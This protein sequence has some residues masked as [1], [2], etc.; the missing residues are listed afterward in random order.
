[1]APLI[2][3]TR[4]ADGS[5]DEDGLGAIS[6][7]ARTTTT[8]VVGTTVHA[9]LAYHRLVYLGDY[10]P[11]RDP[12]LRRGQGRGYE[13]RFSDAVPVPPLGTPASFTLVTDGLRIEKTSGG[14]QES[15]VFITDRLV[16]DGPVSAE[17]TLDVVQ[18]T[19]SVP[20]G[21]LS[22]SDENDFTGIVVGLLNWRH[23]AGLFVLFM[24][25][26]VS[27]GL[28]VRG[29]ALDGSG[30]R[31]ALQGGIVAFDW[32]AGPTTLRLVWNDTPGFRGLVVIADNGVD[33]ETVLVGSGPMDT[34]IAAGLV[35]GIRLAGLETGDDPQDLVT[36]VVGTAGPTV[37]DAIVVQRAAVAGFVAP[38]VLSG[39][40]TPWAEFSYAGNAVVSLR[41]GERLWDATGSALT[42][43]EDTSNIELE[44]GV[45]S[46]G[47]LT[48]EEPDMEGQAWLMLARFS[49][50]T[51]EDLGGAAGVGPEFRTED[52][53]ES[54]ILSCV[55]GPDGARYLRMQTG[56]ATDLSG[57][58]ADGAAEV[59]W[60]QPTTVALMASASLDLLRVE[61]GDEQ[62][63]EDA[64]AALSRASSTEGRARVGWSSGRGTLLLSGVWV[65]PNAVFAEPG[66][67]LPPA[68]TG[69][70]WVNN[71]PSGSASVTISGGRYVLDAATAGTRRFYSVA[72]TNYEPVA[73]GAWHFR[74]KVLRW[75]DQYGAPSVPNVEIG[76]IFLVQHSTTKSVG[77]SFVEADGGRGFV[78]IGG[79]DTDALE[80]VRQTVR[81]RSISSELAITTDTTFV[82][83]VLPG[84]HV[85]LYVDYGAAPAI[86]I[87]WTDLVYRTSPA[88]L[89]AGTAA[90]FGSIGTAAS[91]AVSIQ[92]A[93]FGYGRGYDFEVTPALTEEERVEWVDESVATLYVDLQDT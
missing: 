22:L 52:G 39:G 58:S 70:G 31:T 44:Q 48:T 53:A 37:G 72:P 64:Y 76:P 67:G 19:D 46:A 93:R 1:M 54:F 14:D 65:L 33:V 6:F 7:G 5:V 2:V 63:I 69:Q 43:T 88:D 47:L 30:A 41:A 18:H 35:P 87:A 77:V 11:S 71:A 59:D 61:V 84:R 21:T 81:G 55:Q 4:P 68:L 79:S 9:L 17:V 56:A 83:E 74:G 50:P 73:G 57:F 75:V 20:G 8:R 32:S 27:K 91:A 86:D 42:V 16:P 26:G 25:D 3:N 38:V 10:L 78:F 80:V 49:V 89:P 15:F 34:I 82:L 92:F 24:D 12:G 40:P 45:G 36:V 62:H 51:F 13:G 90:A 66:L 29:Q 28:A 60:T 85:R 23:H